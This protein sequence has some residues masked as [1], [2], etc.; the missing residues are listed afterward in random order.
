MNTQTQKDIL[1]ALRT[2]DETPLRSTA[3]GRADL[4]DLARAR[5]KQPLKVRTFARR[6]AERARKTINDIVV[7]LLKGEE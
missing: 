4:L 5:R 3:E 2:G 1:H 7:G 6:G